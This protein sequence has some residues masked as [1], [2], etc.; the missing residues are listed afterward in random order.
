MIQISL[1]TYIDRLDNVA[2]GQISQSFPRS[3][4]AVRLSPRPAFQQNFQDGALLENY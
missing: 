3:K 2:I 4:P 1:D